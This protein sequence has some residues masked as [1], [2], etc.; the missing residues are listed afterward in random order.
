MPDNPIKRPETVQVNAYLGPDVKNR[1]ELNQDGWALP[2]SKVA[3]PLAADELPDL[4]DWKDP[5]VGWG[6]ILPDPKD[7]DQL[8]DSIDPAQRSTAAGAPEPIVELWKKRG[9]APVFRYSSDL[10]PGHLRR[11]KSDGTSFTPKIES[12]EEGIEEHQIPRYLLIVGPPDV[13]PWELQFELNLSKYVGRLDLTEQG[14]VNYVKHLL[15]D[16]S[17]S[18]ISSNRPVIWS[19]DHRGD[20][21]H[22]LWGSVANPVAKM[23]K[24]DSQIGDELRTLFAENALADKLIDTLNERN[25]ALIITS[26]HGS[27]FPPH[28]HTLMEHNL[29][30]LVDQNNALVTPANLLSDWEPDGAI[31]YAHACC[32]A[33]ALKDSSYAKVVSQTGTLK[34][35]LEEIAKMGSKTSP[36]PRELLSCEKP[37]RAFIGHVELTFDWTIRDTNTRQ[38]LTTDIKEA[39]YQRQ[40]LA[41][42]AQPVPMAFEK[43]YDQVGPLLNQAM[44][45]ER[46]VNDQLRF[47]LEPLVNQRKLAALD[48]RSQVI[49]GDPTV[50][51]PTL[52]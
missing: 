43:Y 51:L 36:T 13:I 27:T 41:S 29:G 5:R 26:S 1:F 15:D 25:P 17:D 21:T 11:Y 47:E 34:T 20:I 8:S 28:D 39:L 45:A 40:H 6:L 16:W 22:E 4:S 33:G 12:S 3:R 18:K 7:D 24:N 46:L 49:L 37:L 48:R 9:E 32:S 38:I 2:T 50:A 42:G 19:V 14:Y 52:V 35:L 30:M 44:E 23:M 31:W 10:A